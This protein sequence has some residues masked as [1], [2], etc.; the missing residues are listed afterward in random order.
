MNEKEI[1]DKLK[2]VMAEVFD[3]D[4]IVL[5]ASTTANDVDGWDSLSNIRMVLAAEAAFG[6]R[7]STMEVSANQNVGE[8]VAMILSK[9]VQR[10]R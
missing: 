3:N 8:F 1:Y 9:T 2:D 5:N 7:F 10:E 4:H 6:V